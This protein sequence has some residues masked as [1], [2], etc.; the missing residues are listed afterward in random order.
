[1]QL[2]QEI[3]NKNQLIAE[4]YFQS[5]IVISLCNLYIHSYFDS[6]LYAV[7]ESFS[8]KLVAF[9]LFHENQSCPWENLSFNKIFYINSNLPISVIPSDF[10][11][12][13]TNYNSDK[14]VFKFNQ[15]KN[16]EKHL[17]E[18]IYNSELNSSQSD[19]FYLFSE[20]TSVSMMFFYQGSLKFSN[21]FNIQSIEEITYFVLSILESENIQADQVL[22]KLDYSLRE[23]YPDLYN[24]IKN[25]IPNSHWLEINNENLNNSLLDIKNRFY[26]VQTLNECE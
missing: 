19:N 18:I 7:Y 9:A 6:V 17:S 25:Y 21:T 11:E 24:E 12:N 23:F 10:V 16:N 8:K 26:F 14:P 4:D 1:M 3:G 2:Q 22:L 13:K 20:K 5:D 15:N